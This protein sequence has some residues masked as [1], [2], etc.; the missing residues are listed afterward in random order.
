[1]FGF[2][3]SATAQQTARERLAQKQTQ[4]IS[5]N[6][7]SVSVRATQ[8]SRGQ[9]TE[10]ENAMWSRSIYRFL[11]LKKEANA[12]LYYPVM[13][14]NG[15][16]N[17]FSMIFRLLIEDKIDAYEYLDGREIFTDEYKIDFMEFLNRF[18]VYHELNDNKIIVEDV[19]IPSNEVQGYF[20]KEAYYFDPITSDHRVKTVAI[21]PVL[22][23]QG[24]YDAATIRYPLFWISYSD[25][26]PYALSMP[27]MASSVNNSMTGTVADYFRKRSYDGEIYK[28][29]NPRNLAISQ[30]AATP[31]EVNIE[32]QKIEAQLRNFE[33]G[34]WRESID[35][36]KV[37]IRTKKSKT[38][39]NISKSNRIS[40]SA[41]SMK[42]RRY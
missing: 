30:Y 3:N 7:S 15:R 16:K 27:V 17:L 39:K 14:E 25:I 29:A 41:N 35:S 21:C 22:L 32:Q 19:D 9:S 26:A 36:T 38:K 20:V 13:P 2:A 40:T 23:R 18:D 31:E 5:D 4:E 12:P 37:D 11:D 10:I 8:A 28:A 34:L 24:D 1:M 33:K 6:T 42:E